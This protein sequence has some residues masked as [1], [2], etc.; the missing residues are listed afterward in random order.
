MVISFW[1]TKSVAY[2]YTMT[3]N[4]EELTWEVNRRGVVRSRQFSSS[5]VHGCYES[6]PGLWIPVAWTP[7]WIIWFDTLTTDSSPNWRKSSVVGI[8]SRMMTLLMQFLRVQ[9]SGF[10][11]EGSIYPTTAGLSVYK[12]MGT[13]LK[14]KWIKSPTNKFLYLRL[15]TFQSRPLHTRQRKLCR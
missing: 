11:K 14:N 12:Y 9:D 3:P 13:M 4:Q 6:H 8:L 1:F 15:Q 2:R 5:Q 10:Y 7:A